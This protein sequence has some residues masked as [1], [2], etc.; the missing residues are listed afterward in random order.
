MSLNNTDPKSGGGSQTQPIQSTQT[1]IDSCYETGVGEN[2]NNYIT[3]S[4]IIG[5]G[6]SSSNTVQWSS[7][8]DPNFQ[9][10]G[11]QEIFSLILA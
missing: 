1:Q 7:K 5:K 4:P 11:D 3:I 10:A 8:D 2:S 6:S 9:G